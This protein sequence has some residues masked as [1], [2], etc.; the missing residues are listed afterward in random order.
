MASTATEMSCWVAG[1]KAARSASD[2][3]SRMRQIGVGLRFGGGD[4][5]IGDQ[6]A[7]DQRREQ[8]ASS[9]PGL[10]AVP[11]VASTSACQGWRPASGARVPGMWP[12]AA[13]ERFVGQD[14]EPL[15][16]VGLGFERAQHVE[17]GGGAGKAEPGDRAR[18]DRR[19]QLEP[20]GGDDAE[21]AF[22]ADQQLVEAGA[23][24]VLLEP[25]Q[26]VVD[27]A[28]GQHR[29]D[30]LDQRAHRPE[31]KHLRAA[32]VGRDQPA[33]GR[34]ALGAERQ[35]EAL[36]GVGGGVV[37][38]F[39]DDA[40]FG[41]ARWPGSIARMRFI[42]RSERISALPSAGGVAPPTIEV[43][44][45]CGT[46]ATP[47]LA[48]QRDDRGDRFDAVGLERAPAKRRAS[49][50]A[51]RS[52]RARCPPASV[53]AA[54]GAEAGAELGRRDALWAGVIAPS[55]ALPRRPRQA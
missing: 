30:P 19:D 23:A 3:L 47:P 25:G 50:R 18:D 9:R 6:P 39:E 17:R 36:A 26:A 13:L 8:A 20:R 7:L 11:T 22:G 24:I 37:E 51:S 32:G 31:A 46:S 40:G 14:L 10:V 48:R 27:R 28:V 12:S 21:R 52:A 49:G 34:A 33:D 44:P 29:L 2:R 45:P 38:R 43:L 42:R 55:F 53:S 4:G 35:R 54:C 41:D 16:A 5:G 15:D 1:P